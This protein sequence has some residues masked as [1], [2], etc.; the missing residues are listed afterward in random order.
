[1]TIRYS[2]L[3][4]APVIAALQARERYVRT[5]LQAFHPCTVFLWTTSILP[6]GTEYVV[7]RCEPEDNR[8]LAWFTHTEIKRKLTEE[9]IHHVI[10]QQ[11]R[12]VPGKETRSS[13]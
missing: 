2:T 12:T 13:N 7:L 3:L 11:N 9:H 4:S 8:C 1:M 10:Q 6:D 5:A